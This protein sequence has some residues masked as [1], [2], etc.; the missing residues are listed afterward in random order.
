MTTESRDAA[1]NQLEV[2]ATEKQSTQSTL[3]T[4]NGAPVGSLTASMTA[5]E[6]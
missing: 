5:G 6:R 4:G 2:Q 3:T 1:T